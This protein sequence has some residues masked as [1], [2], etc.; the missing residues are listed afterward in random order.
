M[1]AGIADQDVAVELGRW[2]DPSYD[3]GAA[4]FIRVIGA[5]IGFVALITVARR[6]PVMVSAATHAKAMKV[7]LFGT[8]VGPFLGVILSMVAVRHAHAAVVG[9]ILSTM[10]VLVLPFVII[11]YGEKVSIRAAAGAV[12]AVIGVALLV[13]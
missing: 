8:L 2:G 11:L 1:L 7:I 5:L 4:T 13:W 3:A 12:I 10:P 6:W 9:T